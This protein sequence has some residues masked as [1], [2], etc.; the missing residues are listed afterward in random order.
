MIY[1]QNLFLV[2]FSLN[3]LHIAIL[4]EENVTET[5]QPE[6]GGLMTADRNAALSGQTLSWPLSSSEEAHR[7]GVIGEYAD[8]PE[9]TEVSFLD[10]EDK[11]Q[12]ISRSAQSSAEGPT[13]K[14]TTQTQ[15]VQELPTVINQATQSRNVYQPSF[16]LDQK[17]TF[18]VPL[19]PAHSTGHPTSTAD[20]G[21]WTTSPITG[22]EGKTQS[23]TVTVGKE[24]GK[25]FSFTENKCFHVFHRS[26]SD[27][28]SVKFKRQRQL[29]VILKC[30][31]APLSP[32]ILL[33]HIPDLLLSEQSAVVHM[34]Y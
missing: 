29:S 10:P 31:L 7:Q 15:S 2:F 22:P 23:G 16:H 12:I 11:G 4:T 19:G 14:R 30:H 28:T 21:S 9:S 33:S 20:A 3:L 25:G 26:K 34:H 5:P 27:I 18:S 1:L 24:T 17:T 6:P 8:L 13:S 32:K